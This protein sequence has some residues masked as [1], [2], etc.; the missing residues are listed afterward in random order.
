MLEAILAILGALYPS[1]AGIIELIL[2][3]ISLI[4]DLFSGGAI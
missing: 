2:Q 1:L 4:T 3:L